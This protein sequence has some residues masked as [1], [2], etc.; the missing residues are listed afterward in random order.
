MGTDQITGVRYLPCAEFHPE[1]EDNG[2]CEGCGWS[3]D[4]HQVDVAA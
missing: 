1:P 3:N 4:D 2:L